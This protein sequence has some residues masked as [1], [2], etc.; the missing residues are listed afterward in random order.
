[1]SGAITTLTTSRL[2]IV[3]L[4]IDRDASGL[5]L[6]LSDPLMDEYGWSTP[7]R[8]VAETRERLRS[9]LEANGG[10]TWV[11]RL[12]PDDEPLGTIGIFGDQGTSIRGLSWH[13][14]R[15]H[16][17]MGIMGEAAPVVIEHLLAQPEITGV[18]AW[19]DTR[20]LR[21]IGVARRAG[22]HEA[23]RMARRYDNHLAQQVVMARASNP[24]D[25][26]VVAVRAVLPVHD[27]PATSSLLRELLGLHLAF[28]YPD[29]PTMARLTVT[30]WTGS[31]GID[32]AH[33]PGHIAPTIVKIDVGIATD[34]IYA[35]ALALGLGTLGPPQD[36][37][38]HR[39]TCT[40]ILPEGH[41]IQVQGSLL[42]PSS[43][44]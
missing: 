7:S 24:S 19:I 33:Q 34:T 8:D 14:R 9:A 30:P 27:I 12:R 6:M 26:D 32:L 44:N 38:W 31:P 3:P 17:G 20:N 43:D 40:I 18:E 42:P 25:S 28:Q 37:E 39:R 1:V 11:I 36:Q 10:W 4:D 29:P 16:W 5:H 22:L 23:A 15:S 2:D 13:L 35:R 41:H 21:S